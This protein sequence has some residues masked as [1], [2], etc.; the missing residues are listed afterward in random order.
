L[1]GAL[2]GRIGRPRADMLVHEALARAD[3]TTLPS[4]A[5][6]LVAFTKAHLID[7]L[8]T[9]LGVREAFL[10]LDD[11]GNMASGRHP[12]AARAPQGPV[13]VVD[14]DRLRRSDVARALIS[15][16]FAVVTADNLQEGASLS[17][18]PAVFVL[19]YEPSLGHELMNLFADREPPAIVLR[20][21]PS[22]LLAAPMLE[23][24]GFAVH[25]HVP[26]STP[27]EIL[28]AVERALRRSA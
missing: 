7:D 20:S 23:R 6:G 19:A 11:L 16:G 26:T 18:R 28:R 13:A 8:V 12:V 27:T 22:T 14:P 1:I 17:P 10:L 5:D 4:D 2:A 3:R 21:C 15:R 9:V 24:A 25:E